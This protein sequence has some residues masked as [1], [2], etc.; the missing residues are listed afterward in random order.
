MEIKATD[1]K[2]LR[3]ATGAGMMDAK[4]ALTE[5]GGDVERAKQLLRE[6]GV[7][8]AAKLSERSAEEGVVDAYL[9]APDPNLP[10]KVGVLVEL[11]CSTDFAAKTE[12]FRDLAREIAMHIAA[13]SPSVVSREQLPPEMVEAEREIIRKQAKT[14]GKPDNVVEKIVEGRLNAF[15]AIHCLLDQAWVRDEKRTIAQL[16]QEVS[17]DVGEPVKVRRFARYRLGVDE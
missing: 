8:K 12:R 4:R 2:A 11:N 17:A 16:L 3:D 5:A 6:W 13:A 10:A 14:E 15:F 9:H 1:V 7:T